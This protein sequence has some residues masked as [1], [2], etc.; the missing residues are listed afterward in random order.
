MTTKTENVLALLQAAM[1]NE[2]E[3]ENFYRQAAADSR[4]ARARSLFE[5]LAEQEVDHFRRVKLEHDAL[6]AGKG[7]QGVS[8]A[9]GLT[10]FASDEQTIAEELAEIS[11]EAAAFKLAREFEEKS[12]D[13]Y[14]QAAGVVQDERGQAILQQL[15]EEE[16]RHLELV[17]EW[18]T[19][20][21]L[22]PHTSA[23]DYRRGHTYL[24]ET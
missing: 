15:A 17:S 3:G 1:Q 21:L 14:Q 4:Q 12:Y 16:R 13:I 10:I 7:W 19:F 5:W 20:H 18:L 8:P 6:A 11:S 22:D 9:E 23:H 24:E 2:L